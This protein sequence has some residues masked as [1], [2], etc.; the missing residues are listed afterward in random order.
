[1]Q[2]LLITATPP[3]TPAQQ[4]A[5]ADNNVEASERFGDVLAR[6][7]ANAGTAD[8]STHESKP[9]A[10]S[11][12]APATADIEQ[13]AGSQTPA[14]DTVVL[15]AGDMLAAMMP[16]APPS[17]SATVAD[18][19]P[20]RRGHAADDASVLPGATA[21]L[22]SS[23]YA[24]LP[25]HGAPMRTQAITAGAPDES[26][27]SISPQAA[28]PL[29]RTQNSELPTPAANPVPGGDFSVALETAGKGSAKAA[30]F[31]AKATEFDT[32]GSAKAAQFD[33]K[34]TEFDTK[35]S[36]TAAQFDAKATEFDTKSAAKAAQFDTKAAEFATRGRD[37][38][39]P[40]DARHDAI[41]AEF[42]ARSNVTPAQFEARAAEFTARD[43]VNTAQFDAKATQT[44]ASA[45]LSAQPQGNAAPVT[46]SQ[47]EPAHATI[48]TP[49]SHNAW[50]DEFS[51][52]ITWL[53]TQREQSAE[54]HLNP[55]QLGPLDVVIKISG[56]QATA[57]FTSPH[58]A[59]RDAVEQALP[60]LREMLSD[61]G[62]MLGN[63]MVSDQSPRE[64]P[65]WLADKQ[66]SGNGKP[67]MTTGSATDNMP[68]GVTA[69]PAR[70]HRGL[71]D[72]FA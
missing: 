21:A 56:D 7:R 55:P 12:E 71:L 4:P 72:T 52:K 22:L 58:A 68:S 49:V 20:R 19:K 66:P 70:R 51:Q 54:L 46:S 67:A 16:S 62:I 6:Q 48:S 64:Q 50:G 47:A 9:A 31:N 3:A 36:A 29:P 5:S 32:R 25:E 33:A 60:K 35:D 43:S 59:V 45:I 44:D 17:S 37:K 28:M 69:L 11:G 61:N 63:T 2:N 24:A 57:L 38:A 42:T 39:T 18:E 1:M 26:T 40:F 23:P 13:T 65:A 15:L 41:A 53:A 27:Q 30:Q 10:A 8:T 14:P 34:A